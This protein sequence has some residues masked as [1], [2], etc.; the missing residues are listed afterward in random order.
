[1]DSQGIENID[2]RTLAGKAAGTV[3]FTTTVVVV[4]VAA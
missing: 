4:P 2:D 1:M 3:W